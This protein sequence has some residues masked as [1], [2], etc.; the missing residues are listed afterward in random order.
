M[1]PVTSN[2]TEVVVLVVSVG[3]PLLHALAGAWHLVRSA[4]G[5]S[6]IIDSGLGTVDGLADGR[7]RNGARDEDGEGSDGSAID[8]LEC[9]W[10]DGLRV[11][12]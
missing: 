11:S 7:A 1:S 3:G 10:G 2:G 12:C 5:Y 6:G 8:R 9:R 4:G